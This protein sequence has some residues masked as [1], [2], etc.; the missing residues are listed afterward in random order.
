MQQTKGRGDRA[1]LDRLKGSADPRRVAEALALPSQGRRFFCPL[2]QPDRGRTPDLAVDPRGFKCFKCGA[3]GDVFA[4]VQ[5]AMDCKFPEAVG[6]L[7]E[8]RGVAIAARAEPRKFARARPPTPAERSEVLGAFLD[9]CPELE[10]EAL[11]ELTRRGIDAETA[12]RM[13]VRWCDGRL[14]DILRALGARYGR[15][16]LIGAGLVRPGKRRDSP[17]FGPYSRAGRPFLIFPYLDGGRVASLKARALGDKGELEREGIPR[18]LNAG[19]P[20][21]CFYNADDLEGEESTVL[22]C[23]GETDTL[24]AAS[25]GF[26]AVGVPGWA[27]FKPEWAG[28]LAGK[29]VLLALDADDAGRRGHEAIAEALKAEGLPEP[30]SFALPEGM[31]LNDALRAPGR[32][33]LGATLERLG[34]RGIRLDGEILEVSPRLG[35]RTG[36]V[37]YPAPPDRDFPQ[38]PDDPLLG[39]LGPVAEGRR[40]LKLSYEQLAPRLLLGILGRRGYLGWSPRED[41]WPALAPAIEA[42]LDDAPPER[43]D[44]EPLVWLLDA[45][46]DFGSDLLRAGEATTPGGRSIPLEPGDTPL[47]AAER[48]ARGTAADVV[49]RASAWI[50][51]DLERRGAPADLALI[52]FDSLWIEAGPADGEVAPAARRLMI[53]AAAAERCEPPI[54]AAWQPA[55]GASPWASPGRCGKVARIATQ[56]LDR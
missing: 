9:R 40:L 22:V 33:A 23:E 51:R 15:N 7:S 16:R 48:L 8:G 35:A 5:A 27:A 46:E 13:G 30:G 29:S 10:G 47:S 44:S 17:T 21:P 42:I 25:R 28:R 43:A 11:L 32:E 50:D 1:W 12:R 38:W 20:V 45:I 54:A 37:I 14:G 6:W 2:C 24:A 3:A 52:W 26:R 55:R 19:G 18:F 53:A 34:R 56:E 36:R 4:L 41:E 49:N 39:R 31:D